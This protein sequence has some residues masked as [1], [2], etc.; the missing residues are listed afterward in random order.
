MRSWS[1]K[2]IFLS[3][4]SSSFLGSWT[5]YCGQGTAG[6]STRR[7]RIISRPIRHPT[8]MKE[9]QPPNKTRRPPSSP[10]HPFIKLT[11]SSFLHAKALF[12]APCIAV[13]YIINAISWIHHFFM[14]F[15]FILVSVWWHCQA[16]RLKQSK[17]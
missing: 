8:Q 12:P 14:I 9:F 5:W 16:G 7:L 15:I 11:T 2:C 3:S 4:V 10:V 6:S 17:K 13:H 1:T